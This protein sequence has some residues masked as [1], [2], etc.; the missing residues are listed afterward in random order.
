MSER[1]MTVQEPRGLQ[2]QPEQLDLLKRTIARGATDD[3]LA[4]FM[5]VCR[6]TGLDPFTGQIYAVKRWDSREKREVMAIQVGIDG[7]RLIGDR[8]GTYAPGNSPTYTFKEDGSLDSCTAYGHK[9][10]KTPDGKFAWFPVNATVWYDEKV[11]RTRSGEPTR[12][13]KESPR[14]QLAK[15]AEAL[16][17]R[18]CAPNETRHVRLAVEVRESEQEAPMLV[19]PSE[20]PEVAVETVDEDTG[21]VVEAEV[22]EVPASEEDKDYANEYWSQWFAKNEGDRKG[23]VD[24][25]AEHGGSF[26]EAL[27]AL[28]ARQERMM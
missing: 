28:G 4:L 8:N 15:C 26:K 10:R 11:Q 18:K 23:G 27:D 7:L 6:L 2:L 24:F 14:N 1:E 9:A 25:L 16:L 21:E 19:Q 12:F 13:W 22:Q 17:I 20:M 3:E 5:E